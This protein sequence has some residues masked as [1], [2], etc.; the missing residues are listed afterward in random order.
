MTISE[1]LDSQETT[2]LLTYDDHIASNVGG[3][4]GYGVAV[5]RN[6]GEGYK[7]ASCVLSEYSMQEIMERH[8]T[9]FLKINDN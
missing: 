9:T 5:R 2:P 7:N 4:A 3:S 6:E 8:M 1:S